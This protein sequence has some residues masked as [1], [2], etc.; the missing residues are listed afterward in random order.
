MAAAIRVLYVDDEQSLLTIATLFLERSG[1]FNITTALSAPGALQLLKQEKFDA[2]I[3]DYQMP[4]MDGI[5]FLVE[6]RKRFGAI[7]FILF[8][9]RGRE[10]IVIQAI[11]SGADFYLQKGGD[12]KAQFAE[13][14]HKIIQ[15]ISRKKAEVLLKESE[16]K[17]RQ[18]VE[19]A[20]EGIWAIDAKYNT[21]YL[22]PRMAEMLEYTVD[23]MQS[24][25]LTSFMDDAGKG[26]FA[27]NMERRRQGITEVHPFEFIT[28]GGR[29][30]YV[31]ISTSPLTDEKGAF[32][33]SIAVISD[34]TGKKQAEEALK[35]SENRYRTLAESSIDNIFIIGKDDIVRYVNSYAARNLQFPVDEIIGK[36][37]KNLFHPDIADKQGKCL[38]KVFETGQAF[39]DE[40]KILFGNQE[41]WND[42]TLVPLKDDEGNVTAVLGVSRDVTER[43]RVEYALRDSEERF[44]MLLMHVPSIAVQGY[45]MDGTA[46]FWYDGAEN[47]YGYS[48]EEAIGKNLVELIIP[49]EMREEVKKAIAY[50]ADSG[51]PIPA[52]EL[53]LMKKDGSRVSVFSSHVI[54]KR[55]QGEME[56]YCLDIDLTEQKRVEEALRQ[57]NKK[58]NHLSSITRHD[59]N[60]Q[61]TVQMG[62]LELLTNSKLDPTQAEYFQTVATAAQRIS[63]LI[64]FTKE[65][66][67]IGVNVPAWH[68]CCTLV[69]TAAKQDPLGKVIVKND[70]PAGTA[71]FADPLIVK[72]CY[73]LIDN[74][75][76]YG[77]KIST[78]R[79][80]AEERDG[81]HVI[82]CEDDGVGIGA[83]EK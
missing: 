6:V 59:I 27:Q 35:E 21:T 54:I 47:L 43:K 36:P 80:S 33:G 82:V 22:N 17:F 67:Q 7:P 62:Y 16:E 18:L 60:N 19:L 20:D 26:I 58:L 48:E 41:F 66:G 71:V 73:N 4:E 68:D 76:R 23:E 51:Q 34:I 83:E 44:R 32:F 74:A 64:Q 8:T 39:R 75:V 65:Y 45:S 28:K 77:K 55:S 61:L 69:D 25:P 52:S 79:F 72:V 3:S 57:A 9:G 11:N 38:Q 53:S 42:T 12:P 31:T 46:N 78:I 40:D 29:R 81:D 49:Q 13:L 24:L 14:S 70:L 63:A 2:I 56:L 30:I 1:D 5:Q 50:M 37:R 10:E 15:A